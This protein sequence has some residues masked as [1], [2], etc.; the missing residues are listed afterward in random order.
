MPEYCNPSPAS[1]VFMLDVDNTLVDNDRFAADLRSRLVADFGDAESA[2]YWTLYAQLRDELGYADYLSALQRFRAGLE[3]HPA[4]LGMSAFLLDY[5]F[6]TALF[7]QAL[8]VLV[9][10]QRHATTVILSDGDVV[11]QPRKIQRAGIAQAVQGRILIYI[12]KDKMLEAVQRRYPARHYVMVDDKAGI[13]ANMKRLMG[14]KL[15]T[16][17]VRQGHYAQRTQPVDPL[18]DRT[19]DTIAELLHFNFQSAGSP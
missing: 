11:F 3:D 6:E 16:V 2:R 13:L 1:L 15:T 14:D 8:Q 7:P 10:L 17:F 18:P 5:P 12:H 19:I 9:H 4:L